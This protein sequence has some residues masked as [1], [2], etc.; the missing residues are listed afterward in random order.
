MNRGFGL[1]DWLRDPE[2]LW[3][4]IAAGL[5][6]LVLVLFVLCLHLANE[7]T[8]YQAELAQ[9][10]KAN[11]RQRNIVSQISDELGQVVSR[12][13]KLAEEQKRM[14]FSPPAANEPTRPPEARP[15]T[16][17]A[18]LDGN[19]IVDWSD[20]ELFS[21]DWGKTGVLAAD[22][23]QD[24]AVTMKDFNIFTDQWQKTEAWYEIEQTDDTDTRSAHR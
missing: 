22:L 9:V 6:V 21:K 11:D 8:R 1:P 14:A 13:D 7:K 17:T 12:L 19:G 10:M 2:W 15:R 24:Y 16:L 3:P 23:D 4:R 5:A 18:D 20:F